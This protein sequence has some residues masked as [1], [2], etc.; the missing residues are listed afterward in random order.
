[1]LRRR[2]AYAEDLS[3]AKAD[4]LGKRGQ[5]EENRGQN[6]H[7]GWSHVPP[8]KETAIHGIK[9]TDTATKHKEARKSKAR[10]SVRSRAVLESILSNE[11]VFVV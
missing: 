6:N 9:I 4:R 11:T 2:P 8:P 1:M 10:A 3:I 5:G 7:G